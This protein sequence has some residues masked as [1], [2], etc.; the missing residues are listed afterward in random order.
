MLATLSISCLTALLLGAVPLVFRPRCRRGRL[1]RWSALLANIGW[2]LAASATL[3]WIKTSEF[4]GARS[5]SP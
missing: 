1:R 3:R 5:Q 2:M 4:R